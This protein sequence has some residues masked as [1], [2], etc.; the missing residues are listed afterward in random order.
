VFFFGGILFAV[1]V[2]ENDK[3]SNNVGDSNHG[4]RIL[5]TTEKETVNKE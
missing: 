3:S 2:T 4:R 1:L 5:S